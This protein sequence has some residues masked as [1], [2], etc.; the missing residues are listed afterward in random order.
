MDAEGGCHETFIVKR[1]AD[2]KVPVIGH[3]S[4][5]EASRGQEQADEG[6]LKEALL[7]EIAFCP[8]M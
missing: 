3:G 2:G 1:A 8:A 7:Q 4:Q 6:V 5:E